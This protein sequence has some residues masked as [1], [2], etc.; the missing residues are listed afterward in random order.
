MPTTLIAGQGG[1]G[2]KVAV[3]DTGIDCGHQDLAG[4]CVYGAN[5]VNGSQPFD[6]NGHGT[7]VGG[8]IA[9]RQNGVGVVGVAPE[10]TVYAVKVMDST[11]SGSWSNVA[12]GIDWAVRNGMHVINMSLGAHDREPGGGRCGRAGGGC[13]RLV[14]ASAGNSGCCNTVGYPAAYDGVLAVAAVDSSEMLAGFS[15][16]GPQVDIAAPGVGIRS[17]VP[18]GSCS[19][20]DPSGVPVV[21]RHLD[22]GAA[23]G[24]RWCVVAI[25][26]MVGYGSREPDDDDC[27]RPGCAGLRQR[28]RLRSR[29]CAG[30][31]RRRGR[32]R[33]LRRFHR[34]LRPTRSPRLWPLP[35]RRMVQR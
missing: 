28:I 23:R 21:E 34:R 12:M 32:R 17:S 8:I 25:A 14:V 13:G 16:T 1:A 15:S 18:T 6:D 19:L 20:C 35:R 7:H 3:I 30:R 11:G 31:H 9:A 2:I 29:G 5:F 22:G 26:R 27:R 10:A 4:G 24:R 33:R